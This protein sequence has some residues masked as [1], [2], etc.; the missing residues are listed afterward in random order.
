MFVGGV[1]WTDCGGLCG[2][3]GWRISL[4]GNPG[5]KQVLEIFLWKFGM[6]LLRAIAKV[7]AKYRD[8]STRRF[9]PS[10]RMTTM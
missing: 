10:P 5:L 7:K 3:G 1:L 2:E 4:V 6:G 8:P 9:A